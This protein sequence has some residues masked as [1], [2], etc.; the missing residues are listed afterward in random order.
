MAE[1]WREYTFSEN[2]PK[3][4]IDRTGNDVDGITVKNYMLIDECTFVDENSEILRAILHE[5][6]NNPRQQEQDKQEQDK[7]EQ[8]QENKNDDQNRIMGGTSTTVAGNLLRPDR[9]HWDTV[10]IHHCKG[11]LEL[12]VKEIMSCH[13]DKLRFYIRRFIEEPSSSSSSLENYQNS[14]WPSLC[15]LL[16]ESNKSTIFE[17]IISCMT[18]TTDQIQHLE[19]ELKK[20]TTP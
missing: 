2:D 14:I 7:Q 5:L 20:Q 10:E 1:S 8:E 17:L 3:P 4:T 19:N 15:R 9:R 16:L 6:N 18:I 11:R 13:V 12:L